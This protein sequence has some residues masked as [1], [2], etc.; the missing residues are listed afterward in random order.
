MLNDFLLILPEEIL[1]VGALLLMLAAAWA[2]DRSARVLTWLA[3]IVLAVAAMFLPGIK[4]AG[5]SAFDGL[6]VA[7]GFAAFAKIVIL[8]GA[9]VALLM[10]MSWFGRDRDYRAEY[11]V[12]ILFSALGMTIMVSAADLLTLS[13]GLELQSLA[14]Y[15]LAS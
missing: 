12:L 10:A 6:F 9:A 14:A 7:D 3:V 5:G 2:G 13:V 15:V 8:A 11:P 4:G 1:G